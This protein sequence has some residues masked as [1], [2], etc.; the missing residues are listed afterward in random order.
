M[1]RCE[2]IYNFIE[3]FNHDREKN[4]IKMTLN[5]EQYQQSIDKFFH[6]NQIKS[7]NYFNRLIRFFILFV[8]LKI[9]ND[10]IQKSNMKFFENDDSHITQKI[11][12]FVKNYDF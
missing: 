8:C 4:I 6:D 10:K 9:I 11:S 2:I 7:K 3:R 5:F 1:N 12:I